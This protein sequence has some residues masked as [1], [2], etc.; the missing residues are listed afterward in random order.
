MTAFAYYGIVLLTTEVLATE[1]TCSSGFRNSDSSKRYSDEC[2]VTCQ[3]LST[4]DYVSLSLTSASELLSVVV[5]FL[6]I[7]WIGRKR[8]FAIAAFSYCV[9]M[10]LLNLC[11]H[12]LGATVVLFFARASVASAV[13]TVYVYAPEVYP[14]TVRAVGL[15]ACSSFARLGAVLTPLIAQVLTKS[16]LSA[17]SCLYAIAGLLNCALGL[18][19]PLETRGR[20]IVDAVRPQNAL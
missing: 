15:G 7:D 9:A 14:T 8:T 10:L 4:A 19:L 3:S 12:R 11:V 13:Q 20:P 5:T 1:G 6:V 18:S 16:S 17:A 2:Y